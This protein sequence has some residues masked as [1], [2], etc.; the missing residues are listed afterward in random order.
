MLQTIKPSVFYTHELFL[1]ILV[2]LFFH[3]VSKW[4]YLCDELQV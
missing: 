3:A 2:T 4:R 1:L